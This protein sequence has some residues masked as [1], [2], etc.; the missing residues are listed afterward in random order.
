MNHERCLKSLN[1]ERINENVDPVEFSQRLSDIANSSMPF[2]MY[3]EGFWCHK[4]PL[5]GQQVGDRLSEVGLPYKTVAENLAIAS[6]LS[7]RTRE[8]NE[9]R[10]TQKYNLGSRV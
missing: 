1:I 5:N 8:F 10:N 6:T 7:C 3:E 4:N 2:L 9:L